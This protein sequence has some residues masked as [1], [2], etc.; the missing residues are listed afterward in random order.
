MTKLAVAF[1][2]EINGCNSISHTSL[3]MDKLEKHAINHVPWPAYP[4]KPEVHF[5][6]AYNE[7]CIFLK[8]YVQEH[9]VRAANGA[10][11]APV[12]QD[13]CVEF[14]I[15]FD[16]QGYYNLEFNCIGTCLA[17]FGKQR[18]GRKLLPEERIKKIQYQSLIRSEN[19]P[20]IYW[21][22]TVVIP[23]TVFMH[24]SL[25]SLRGKESRANFYKCGDLLP[26]PHFLTWSPIQSAA[27]DFHLPECFGL[28][29]F[30]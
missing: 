11:H 2:Q 7:T 27:P 20:A 26:N 1:F 9:F 30:G 10:V 19:G 5:S 4:Y 13:S 8:Y 17:G 12:Y 3:F 22:L 15:L 24:H 6:I 28:V 23:L 25:A 29:I 16:D 18:E 21:E 14:F